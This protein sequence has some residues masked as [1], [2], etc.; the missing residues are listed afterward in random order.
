MGCQTCL[1]PQCVVDPPRR[2]A[3][4]TSRPVATGVFGSITSPDYGVHRDRGRTDRINSRT[5][6][7]I[8][9]CEIGGAFER[10]SVCAE[11]CA[12]F[13][14]RD[15]WR[16]G[17]GA[18]VPPGHV[19]FTNGPAVGT[20]PTN[21]R[22]AAGA[23]LPCVCFSLKRP[24][25]EHQIVGVSALRGPAPSRTGMDEAGVMEWRRRTR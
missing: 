24:T 5:L 23:R 22:R 21:N 4:G 6:P 2:E 14:I 8:A 7:H 9:M 25:V 17:Q 12:P 13:V 20:P 15:E 10:I 1:V 11:S 3:Q 18:E 16:G 19:A